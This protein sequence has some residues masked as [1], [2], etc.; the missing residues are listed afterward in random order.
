MGESSLEYLEFGVQLPTP[1]W[2]NLFS[3]PQ[4]WMIIASSTAILPALAVLII[5]LAINHLDDELRD[6]IAPYHHQST[7]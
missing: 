2:G 5:L 6:A 3:K 1:T 4:N 7:E